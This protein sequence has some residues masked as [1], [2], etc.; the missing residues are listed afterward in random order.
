MNVRGVAL[1]AV[2]LAIGSGASSCGGGDDGETARPPSEPDIGVIPAGVVSRADG[3]CRWMLRN[4]KRVARSVDLSDY[5]SGFQ[6]TTEAFAKPG[7]K[8]VKSL[9]RRQGSL[10]ASADDP[11]FDAYV[12]LFDPIIVLGEQR[13]KAGLAGQEARSKHLQDLLTELGD[14]QREA[15]GQAG[16]AACD[17]DFLE[18]L[19]H[20]AFG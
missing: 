3:N 17:V 19:V 7:I 8:L 14:E 1:L 10:R 11:R 18:V 15:A 2:V 5:T 16:L 13:L 9:A 20:Q 4:V 12:E 6:L